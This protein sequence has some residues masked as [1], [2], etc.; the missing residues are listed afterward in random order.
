MQ[1]YT[2]AA[3]APAGRAGVVW[4]ETNAEK[5]LRKTRCKHKLTP[6][7]ISPGSGGRYYCG[8]V[9]ERVVHTMRYIQYL[10]FRVQYRGHWQ[11]A[12][13]GACGGSMINRVDRVVR[14]RRETTRHADGETSRKGGKRRRQKPDWTKKNRFCRLPPSL[15]ASF[16]RAAPMYGKDGYNKFYIRKIDGNF[17]IWYNK[18]V[19]KI[20]C[21]NS[22][23]KYNLAQHVLACNNQNIHFAIKIDLIVIHFFFLMYTYTS[24]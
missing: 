19:S 12:K 17:E 1:T 20:K 23:S 18:H 5:N 24:Y 14:R 2:R 15:M 4:S 21:K 9:R 10:S 22:S 13:H 11:R 6:S 7:R 8:L 16:S 3:S